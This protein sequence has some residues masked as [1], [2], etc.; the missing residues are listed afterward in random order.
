MKNLKGKRIGV[1]LDKKTL[2]LERQYRRQIG[3][4][5][6]RAEI[7]RDLYKQFLKTQI[8]KYEKHN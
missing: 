4:P 5:K 2:E 1:T 7:I 8:R 6:T 3:S